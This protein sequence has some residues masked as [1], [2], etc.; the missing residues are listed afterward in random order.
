MTTLPTIVL[1][2]LGVVAIVTSGVFTIFGSR[3]KNND[4]VSTELINKLT[5]LREADKEEF[6]NRLNLL[7]EQH[8]EDSKALSSMSGQ[9]DVLKSIPLVNIDTTLKEIAKFNKSIADVNSK[10]LDRLELTASDLVAANKE[11]A[12]KVRKVKEDLNHE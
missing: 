2:G 11:V 5:A 9:I 6:S 3:N 1:D 4:R 12:F 10:I 7:E 8:L